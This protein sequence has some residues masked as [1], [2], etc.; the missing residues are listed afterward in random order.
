MAN[1]STYRAM[2]AAVGPNG[3]SKKEGKKVLL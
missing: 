2:A 3:K 1:Y